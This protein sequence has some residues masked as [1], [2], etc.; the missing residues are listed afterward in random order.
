MANERAADL[1]LAVDL[2]GALVRADLL[3][4]ASLAALR[5]PLSAL[6]GL[7]EPLRSAKA[8][9]KRRIAGA[10]AADPAPLAYDPD[11]VAWLKDER[12]RGRRIVLVGAAGQAEVEAVAAELGVFDAACGT[13]ADADPSG[14]RRLGLIRSLIGDRFAFLGGETV[15]TP[16]FRAAEQ[17]VLVG[18]GTRRERRLRPGQSVERRFDPPRPGLAVWLRAMRLRHWTKNVLVFVAPVLALKEAGL[19]PLGAALL[20]FLAF[21]LL[22]SATYLVNDL[23][24]IAADRQHP[25]KRHRPI[26]AGLIPPGAAVG[27]AAALLGG[28]ALIAL[29]L[30]L[31][32]GLAL[33]AYLAIT[34][35]Y[36]FWLKRMPIVD[37]FVLASLFTLRV[38]AG[39]LLLP[40]GVSAWLLSFSLLFF[41]GL[42]IV[43]RHVELARVVAAGGTGVAARGYTARDLPLLLAAGVAS[44]FSAIIIFFLYLVEEQYPS[45]LY[46]RPEMLWGLM[47]VILLWSLRVWHL[48]VHGRMNE[49]PVLFA[50]KDG[51][52][53]WLGV[54]CGVLLLMAWL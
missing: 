43:K 49:D 36:S 18:A 6:L 44:S 13:G 27:M 28:A 22:A 20:L 31:S 17:V 40:A 15:D 41:L 4:A 23:L 9:V 51:F 10:T 45:A 25:E 46:R 47:P 16:A 29:A 37:T 30:P 2:D 42:A 1:P 50:L 52:S 21:G 48:T 34:L 8:E 11:I 7:S 39:G 53:R 54:V 38:L 19:A 3:R 35:C 26:A 24:D 33:V 5:R 32:A 12:A 14:E